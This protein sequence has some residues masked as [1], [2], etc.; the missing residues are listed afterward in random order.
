MD[1]NRQFDIEKFKYTENLYRHAASFHVASR[2]PI[3]LCRS[4]LIRQ[5]FNCVTPSDNIHQ[6]DP[7]Y[8]PHPSPQLPITSRN[9]ES[10]VC[11]YTLNDAVISIS[12]RMYAANAFEAWVSGDAGHISMMVSDDRVGSKEKESKPKG[13]A[14]SMAQFF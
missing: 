13:Y 5:P 2:I 8:L 7:W 6:W 11:S 1:N 4:A 3:P 14:I 12:S 9:Y 10:L